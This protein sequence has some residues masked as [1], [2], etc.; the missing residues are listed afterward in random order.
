[1][2]S[3]AAVS[4]ERASVERRRLTRWSGPLSRVV[5]FGLMGVAIGVYLLVGRF[6]VSSWAGIAVVAGG[7]LTIA[8]GLVNRKI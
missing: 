3:V 7:V 5:P 6:S 4:D 1:M 2:R 8:Y